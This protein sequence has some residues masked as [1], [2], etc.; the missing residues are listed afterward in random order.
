M[1]LLDLFLVHC[2]NS[3]KVRVKPHYVPWNKDRYSF[4]FHK[5][6]SKTFYAY[7]KSLTE[8]GFNSIKVRVKQGHLTHESAYD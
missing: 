4:Q 2:F 7:V 5:G 3:I 1:L 8:T 6:T